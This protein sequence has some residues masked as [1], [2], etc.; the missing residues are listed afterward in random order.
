MTCKIQ[1]GTIKFTWKYILLEKKL[2]EIRKHYVYRHVILIII[3]V[4]LLFWPPN[5]KTLLFFS[6]GNLIV[7][8]HMSLSNCLG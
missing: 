4:Q 6:W 1:E 2:K 3:I 7:S 5:K 8:S